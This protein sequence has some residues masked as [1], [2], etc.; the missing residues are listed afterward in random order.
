MKDFEFKVLRGSMKHGRKHDITVFVQK[1]S[2]IACIQ[3]WSYQDTGIWRA[4]SG[5]ANPGETLEEAAIREIKEETNL[6]ISLNRFLLIVNATFSC[7]T[8]KEDWTSYVFHSTQVTGKIKPNDQKEICGAKWV[9]K[10]LLLGAIREIM[11]RTDWGGF[12]YRIF[13]T[14]KAFDVLNSGM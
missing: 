13:L 6:N 3:K 10:K 4:P 9:E 14:E 1:E 7:N 8:E 12:R 2:K 11:I 5:G